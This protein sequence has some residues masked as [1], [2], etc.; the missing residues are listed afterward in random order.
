MSIL[1]VGVDLVEV[2]RIAAALDR[3]GDGFLRR[4]YTRNEI[5]QCG[6]RAERLA[7]RFA[8]KEAV[9][10]AFGTGIGRAMA[11]H[12]IEVTNQETGQPAIALHG[13]AAATAAARG[14]PSIHLSLSHTAT[15]AIAF[16]VVAG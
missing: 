1:G 13:A 12:E 9:A 10:K 6:G 14:S 3:H 16:V 11:F 7:A 2:A 5:A 8:A 4:V 15:D